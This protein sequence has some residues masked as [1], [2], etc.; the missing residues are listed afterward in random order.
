MTGS[1]RSRCAGPDLCWDPLHVTEKMSV[2]TSLTDSVSFAFPTKLP[3]KYQVLLAEKERRLVQP[4]P[5]QG[6]ED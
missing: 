4:R 1:W 2:K 3:I 6:L 5:K